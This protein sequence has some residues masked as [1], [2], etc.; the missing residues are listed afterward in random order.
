MDKL[1]EAFDAVDMVA[2][3]DGLDVT[4]AR[5]APP[6][7]IDMLGTVAALGMRAHMLAAEVCSS[8]TQTVAAAAE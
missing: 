8:I 3:D 6:Q 7:L 5:C 1:R 4:M 2:T